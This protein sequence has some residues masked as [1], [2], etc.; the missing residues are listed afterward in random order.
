VVYCFWGPARLVALTVFAGLYTAA[1]IFVALGARRHLAH[2]G[3][4][5]AATLQ[6]VARD[7]AC[8]RPET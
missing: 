3:R 2:E 1:F 7:R 5:F 4:P 8:I 6:E